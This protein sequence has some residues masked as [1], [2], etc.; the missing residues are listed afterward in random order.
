MQI[1]YDEGPDEI[2]VPAHGL[3]LRRGVP[4]E[5]PAEAAGREPGD[6]ELIDAADVDLD[7]GRSYAQGPDGLWAV[8]DPGTGLLAQSTF[9]VHRTE[10]GEVRLTGTMHIATKAEG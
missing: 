6:P 5:V 10:P 2:Y 4:V 9:R 3:T 1:I 8:R 7:D